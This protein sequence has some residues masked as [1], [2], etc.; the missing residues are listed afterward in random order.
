MGQF[1]CPIFFAGQ[2]ALLSNF[3]TTAA[4]SLHQFS[5]SNSKDAL[6]KRQDVIRGVL[7][8]FF[9]SGFSS[10]FLRQNRRAILRVF[11]APGASRYSQP[12]IFRFRIPVRSGP[13]LFPVFSDC[14]RAE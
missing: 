6:S 14:C 7:S 11:D 13:V 5:R 2:K 3:L 8:S 4:R 12:D 1:P 10:A 9:R